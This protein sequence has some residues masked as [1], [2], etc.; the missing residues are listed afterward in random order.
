VQCVVG[1]TIVVLR[2]SVG[3]VDRLLLQS[4]PN[5]EG[6]LLIPRIYS[7]FYKREPVHSVSFRAIFLTVGSFRLSFLIVFFWLFSC[8]GIVYFA[9]FGAQFLYRHCSTKFEIYTTTKQNP[10]A[11][12]SWNLILVV[13]RK[14]K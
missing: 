6:S 4:S 13:G 3:E 10:V 14:S 12:H 5:V 8:S 7:F 1:Q 9:I 11:Y 2:Q